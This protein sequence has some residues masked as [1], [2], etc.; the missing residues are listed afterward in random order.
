M[1]EIIQKQLNSVATIYNDKLLPAFFNKITIH[2][3]A[4]S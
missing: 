4:V 2:H 1:E 3:E